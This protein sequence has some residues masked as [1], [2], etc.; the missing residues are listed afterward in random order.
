M[1]RP[2]EI[3]FTNLGE[4]GPHPVLVVSRELLNRG[5]TV[6]AVLIT[7]ARFSCA[8]RYLI[9]CLSVRVSSG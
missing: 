2:G 7:S 4:A 6:V 9:V 5:N 8:L 1:I 3:Y